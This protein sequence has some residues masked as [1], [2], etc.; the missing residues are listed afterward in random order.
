MMM[1]INQIF[2]VDN[3]NDPRKIDWVQQEAYY[4]LKIMQADP[5]FALAERFGHNISPVALERFFRHKERSEKTCQIMQYLLTFLGHIPSRSDI[6][7]QAVNPAEQFRD[8]LRYETDLLLEEDVKDA[9]FLETDHK[10][11]AHA[12]IIWDIQENI[13]TMN[14]KLQNMLAKDEANVAARISSMCRVLEHLCL[15][16]FDV[17]RHDIRRTR[18]SDIFMYLLAQLVRSHCWQVDP[19]EPL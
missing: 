6:Q 3:F 7:G 12:G 1:K 4:L 5:N 15:F 8:F 10:D 16:W 19:P 13:L 2:S 11:H 9:V 14:R 17:R 18:R